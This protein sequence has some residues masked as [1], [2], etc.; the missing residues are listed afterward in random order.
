MMQNETN[1]AMKSDHFKEVIEF[2]GS[3]IPLVIIVIGLIGNTISFFVFTFDEKMKTINSMIYLS[4][5]S[6]TDTLSLFVWNLNHFLFPHF[7]I[8][9]EF[10]SLFNCKLFVFLQYFS[11]QCSGLLLSMLTIDRYFTVATLPGNFISKLPFRTRR[12][13]FIWSLII[14]FSIFILNIHITILN[15]VTLENNVSRFDM[16]L[17]NTSM[18]FN[19]Y[20]VCYLYPTTFK[21]F[22]YWEIVHLIIYS[23]VPFLLMALFNSLLIYKSLNVCK[24]ATIAS[25][26][27]GKK[28]KLTVSLV[29]TTLVFLLMT[30]PS[31]IAF[32]FFMDELL[33]YE[34]GEIILNFLDH[35]SYL[36]R[37]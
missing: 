12:N 4:F 36:N 14:T 37:S 16:Y 23:A 7:K 5:I 13:S 34:Y 3:C 1:N 31:S 9:I 28:L 18:M 27:D 21:V 19:N 26:N 22:P 6:I 10:L 8:Q 24:K 15:G 35:F 11:L 33:L 25:K 30:L 17:F 20:F 29:I 2:I 32:G